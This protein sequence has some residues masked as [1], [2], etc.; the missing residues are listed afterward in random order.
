MGKP[1]IMRLLP[2]HYAGFLSQGLAS[3]EVVFGRQKR[4]RYMLRKKWKLWKN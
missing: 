4:E 1:T 2:P 3:P